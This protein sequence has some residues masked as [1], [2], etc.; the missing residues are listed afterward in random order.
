METE[1]WDGMKCK[2]SHPMK[3]Y[4]HQT[5]PINHLPWTFTRVTTFYPPASAQAS[6]YKNFS[7]VTSWPSWSLSFVLPH[8]IIIM[9][10]F[11]LRIILSIC[12]AY[13]ILHISPQ[14]TGCTSDLFAAGN[15]ASA[16]NATSAQKNCFL[17]FVTNSCSPR[18]EKEDVCLN[19]SY[20]I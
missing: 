8:L 10:I 3:H 5:K 11:T 18:R 13:L 12:C 4:Q 15:S 1:V 6:F 20:K 14:K 16:W 2:I 7:L 9:K 17:T 19:W